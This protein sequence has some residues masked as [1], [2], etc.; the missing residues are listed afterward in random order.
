M[1]L[2]TVTLWILL[3]AALT[4]G[5]YWSFLITPE[6]T[7][8]ML[9]VSALLLLTTG[10]LAGLTL[11][12]A[13]VGWRDGVSS[14]LLRTSVATVPAAIPAALLV[15]A[16]WWLTG[17]VTDRIT[18]NS[19]PINAWFIATLGWDDVAWLFTGIDWLASWL[20]WVVAP[21][22]GLAMMGRI[23]RGGWREL[24]GVTW[25]RHGLAPINLA[26]ATLCFAA[27]VAVPWIY[28]APWRPASLPATT[29]ELVFIIAKLSVTAV[30]MATGT[31]LIIR[32]ATLESA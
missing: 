13:I 16:V 31:A 17:A 26:V 18:I 24:P 22:L 21:L 7:I 2:V 11:G 14:A 19:G 6:S 4:G 9:I 3:G 12:G 32:Q 29:L 5:A 8:W 23:I 30:L 25:L 27:F 20:K 1:R 28:L 10:S 15:G